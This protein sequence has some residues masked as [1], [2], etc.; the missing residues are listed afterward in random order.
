MQA[1]STGTSS[2]SLSSKWKA[3]DD[4]TTWDP[5]DLTGKLV[6]GRYLVERVVGAGGFGVV[7]RVQHLRLDSP[8]ALKVLRIPNRLSESRRS[9]FVKQFL[10][11]GKLL[12][13]LGSIHP[14]IVRVFE[15]GLLTAKDGSLAPYLA[16]DWLDGIPLDQQLRRMRELGFHHL[17]LAEVLTLLHP[18]ADCLATAHALGVAHLD[19][20]PG[21]IFLLNRGHKVS[22]RL[23]DFGL[24]KIVG[25][26]ASIPNW[27]DNV[28]GCGSAMT[29]AYAAPEQWSDALGPTGPWTDVHALALVCVE[30]LSG[31]RAFRGPSRAHL[32]GDCLDETFR[33]TPRNLGLDVP[34]GV[35]KVF[36]R[37]LA[38]DP[39]QRYAE[40]RDF[41]RALCRAGHF[42]AS[43]SLAIPRRRFPSLQQQGEQSA[44][45]MWLDTTVLSQ[46]MSGTS[47]CTEIS[48]SL[49]DVLLIDDAVRGHRRLRRWLAV[50]LSVGVFWLIALLVR[51]R[52][53]TASQV[54]ASFSYGASTG[55]THR[56]P[57]QPPAGAQTPIALV[58]PAIARQTTQTE[59][60]LNT[61][62]ASIRIKGTAVRKSSS[63]KSTRVVERTVPSVSMFSDD[64]EPSVPANATDLLH[65]NALK[66]R[67]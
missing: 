27:S 60:N 63:P 39:K 1:T 16:M 33:P 66:T 28:A 49:L 48:T 50:L 53:N 57:T 5:F 34:A 42:T 3:G 7:Y 26:N 51:G 15:A 65:H 41:W 30:L 19:V 59:S 46:S 54:H 12:F 14:T 37:A 64:G 62:E 45:P 32:M 61:A 18:I 17:K 8:V 36:A 31:S 47:G 23:L 21:N 52:T 35:E 2:H 67:K 6:D 24:A 40:A 10:Q 43:S 20:K 22:P 55:V 11:E 4:A 58:G 44:D 9:E 38:V 29:P 25:C 13:R 56:L